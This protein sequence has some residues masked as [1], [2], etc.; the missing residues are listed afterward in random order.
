MRRIQASEAKRHFLRLL[1]EVEKGE[2]IVITRHGKPVARVQPEVRIDRER[3]EESIKSMR[4]L[5]KRAGRLSLEEI[6]SSRDE[7]RV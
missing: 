4:E 1:D 5:R 3:V 2:T 7:G 6:L